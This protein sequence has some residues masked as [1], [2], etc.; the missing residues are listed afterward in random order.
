MLVNFMNKRVRKLECNPTISVCRILALLI[1][2]PHLLLPPR[3][4]HQVC[5]DMDINPAIYAMVQE[6]VSRV[7]D[8]VWRQVDT[9]EIPMFVAFVVALI[10]AA[11]AK[12]Q[13]KCMALN[14][15]H[16]QFN[17]TPA[18]LPV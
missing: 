12:V 9:Q 17:A 5:L 4:L 16:Y 15:K 11:S 3:P 6:N 14:N 7:T 13:E 8:M 10:A 2:C 18:P 1:V